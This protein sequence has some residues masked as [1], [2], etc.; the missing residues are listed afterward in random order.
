M[1][2]LRYFNYPSKYL[3]ITTDFDTNVNIFHNEIT[4]LK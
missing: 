1:L 4:Y 3:C 2:S